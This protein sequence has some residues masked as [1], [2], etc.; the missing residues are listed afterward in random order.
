MRVEL[1]LYHGFAATG[2]VEWSSTSSAGPWTSSTLPSPMSVTD[3][4]AYWST[5]IGTAASATLT[6]AWD[7][8]TQTV[9]VTAST[10]SLWVRLPETLA[11]LLGFTARV[12]DTGDAS[13][14]TPLG[15]ADMPVG[16]TFPMEREES[17]VSE[18]RH[19]RARALTYGRTGT[20]TLE[21]LPSA[22]Q[23]A[24]LEG[25]A[26]LSGLAALVVT[27]DN[28]NDFGEADL[29]GAL[30]VFPTETAGI[31]YDAP[32]S[33]PLITLRGSLLDPGETLT[34]TQTTDWATF[35]SAARFGYG[36]TY[37][38]Q[39]EGI[40][41]RFVE[42]DAPIYGS[43]PADDWTNDASL[44]IDRAPKVGGTPDERTHFA[45][46]HD[47]DLRLLDTAAV[48]ALMTRPTRFATLTADIDDAATTFTVDSTS[49][50]SGVTNLYI[51]T[52]LETAAARS[53]TSW[54]SITRGT[55][56]QARSYK[57]GTI[58]ADNPY[59]WRGRRVDVWADLLDP[60]GYEVDGA[61]VP[62]WAGYV[63]ARPERDGVEWSIA[64]R[65]QMR[66]LTQPLGVAASG[67]ARWQIDDDGLVGVDLNAILTVTVESN[68]S[69]SDSVQVRPFLGQTS[70][71]GY[72]A[73]TFRMSE[74]RELVSAALDAAWT[75]ADLGKPTWSTQ[76]STA[77]PLT[78]RTWQMQIPCDLD[79]TED[80]VRTTIHM[81]ANVETLRLLMT[82]T[83]S[84]RTN[85]SGTDITPVPCDLVMY[86]GFAARD[87]G[88]AVTLDDGDPADLPTTG[89]VLLEGD[90]G[91]VYKRYTSLQVD[92]M[93]PVTVHLILDPA[94]RVSQADIPDL[95]GVG[96]GGDVADISATF[97][98]RDSGTVA[99]VLRRAIVSTGDGTHGAYD[100]LPRGQGLGLPGIDADSFDEVFDGFLGDLSA[101]IGSNAGTTL[102]EL[103]GGL[104]VLSQRALVAR[105]SGSGI[106][107]AAARVGSAD[108]VPVTTITERLLV[109][110]DGKR[111]VRVMSVYAAPQAM[112]VKCRTLPVD[113]LPAGE[114]LI[115]LRDRH[116]TDWT[117]EHWDLDVYGFARS[118][119]VDAAEAWG[120]AWF[121]AGEN[122]QVVE[123][124]VPPWVD[125]QAGD[126]VALEL[127]DPSLWDYATGSA[128]LSGLA[129]VLGCQMSLVTG[130][131]TL[132]VSV[133]GIL[134]AGP[135]SPSLPISAVNGGA[136]TPTSIDVDD[137]FY[138]L[139]VRAKDS[140]TSWKVLAY[141]PGQDAGR[142][143]YTVSTVTQPGGGVARLTVTAYPSSPAV[144]LST[145]WRI[146]WPVSTDSTTTQAAYLHT[147]T[148][149]QWS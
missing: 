50:W 3:A 102:Q 98:W 33:S 4:L 49:G 71:E 114:G 123:L 148:K 128:G 96:S 149:G 88:L 21:L 69:I 57:A 34:A 119:L 115:A 60:C 67:K 131:Q 135:M 144:S 103:F 11:T 84:L 31:E 73:G 44:V 72:S 93:D 146:T 25:S 145:S 142:A 136:T 68:G 42:Y 13:N 109:A 41:T 81:D 78:S 107:V 74:V 124:D 37:R 5:A 75:D 18:Y 29:D 111:P 40:A 76:P 65:D 38:A 106:V 47:L 92:T 23:W 82:I 140:E 110:S 91:A 77:I 15:I 99:D 26:M 16:Y 116:L 61:E 141:L 2:T 58:I 10:A 94:S 62:V 70:R 12:H 95:L 89:W 138:D 121:R 127:T 53:A 104:L 108:S 122:R 137:A 64:C 36:A 48:R 66:R 32:D 46:A 86:N 120:L 45:K 105:R 133:D 54:S 24:A 129:R 39:I 35:W 6:L 56:G 143:E 130:V 43:P 90:S 28:A 80:W 30:M 27:G 7:S 118:V 113:A 22:S 112:E 55:Y 97:F 87:L 125:A 100:T 51:G 20:V 126:V 1:V 14:L 59:E 52:S 139:L 9:T 8:A 83:S 85:V 117:A 63:Q 132:T 101:A 79:G 147:D 17:E 134:S 19:G